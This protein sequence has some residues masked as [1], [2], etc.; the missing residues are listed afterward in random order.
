MSPKPRKVENK[1]MPARWRYKHGAYYYRVPPGLEYKWDGKSEFRLGK[2]QSEAYREWATRIELHANAK[3]IGELLERYEIEEIPKKA[4]KTQ[5]SYL[6]AVKRLRPIFGHMMIAALK[7]VHVFQYRDMRGKQAPTATNHEIGVLSH[8]YSKAI[9]WGLAEDNPIKGKVGKI[10]RPP[11]RRYV[12]DWELDEALK[13]ASPF[14]KGYIELKLR[15]GLRRGDMLSIRLA[16]L[17]TDGIRVTPRK[18]QGTTGKTVVYGWTDDLRTAVDAVMALR[19]GI[20][21]EWLFCTRKGKCYMNENGRSNSFDSVWQR[22]MDKALKETGLKE[23]FT[24]HD[25]RAKVASDNNLDRAQQLLG[26]SSSAITD[27]V[28]RRKAETIAPSHRGESEERRVPD[29][30]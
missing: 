19:N 6:A 11:R 21:S 5:E 10:S 1:G 22:F 9:E 18:T 24:E 12:E 26:H 20:E 27:R 23:R 14:I 3:T 25:L 17:I 8:A 4:P 30:R 16:D 29:E 13:V 2:T 28:Y 7:P 15:L